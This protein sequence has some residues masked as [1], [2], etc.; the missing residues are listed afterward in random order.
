MDRRL[1]IRMVSN[2]LALLR[3]GLCAWMLRLRKCNPRHLGIVLR[4]IVR[5]RRFWEGESLNLL[6]LQ[7]NVSHVSADRDVQT[8]RKHTQYHRVSH[9]AQD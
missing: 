5:G 2:M 7:S 1:L 6:L 9:T 4:R 8:Y 3:R